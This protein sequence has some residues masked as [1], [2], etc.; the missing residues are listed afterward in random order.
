MSDHKT[1]ICVAADPGICGFLCTVRARMAE[2]RTVEVEIG[3]S[4]CKHIRRLSEQIKK[5]SLKELFLPL[6]KNPIFLSAQMA[7]CHPSC[8]IP[9]AVVKAVEA[10]MEMAIPR[11]ARIT[12][13]PP[14]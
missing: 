14:G 1:E 5:I 8:I 10:A 12:F 9:V 11:N 6:T 13:S 7:G 2:A 3:D 4:E